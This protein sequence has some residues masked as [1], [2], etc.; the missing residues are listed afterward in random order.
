MLVCLTYLIRPRLLGGLGRHNDKIKKETTKYLTFLF[1]FYFFTLLASKLG[2]RPSAVAA[3]I[4]HRLRAG[5]Q[6]KD[7]HPPRGIREREGELK[8]KGPSS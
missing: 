1:Y 7:Y 2:R 5:A 8:P 3:R 4:L 6:G